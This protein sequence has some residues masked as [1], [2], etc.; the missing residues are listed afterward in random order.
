[1][2]P[3]DVALAACAGTLARELIVGPPVIDA[4]EETI[5]YLDYERSIAQAR[6]AFTAMRKAR[7]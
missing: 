4:V 2:R 1:M 3:S 6:V 5:A 7:E